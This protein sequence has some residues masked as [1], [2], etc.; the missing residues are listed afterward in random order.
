MD[1]EL[2]MD[3]IE[4]NGYLGL[5]LWLWFGVFG[6]P[7]PN[8]VISMTVGLAASLGALHPISA[9]AVTYG[10]IL[11]ALT[12]L[13]MLG[14]LVGSRLIS[15][16]EKKKRLSGTLKKS[17]MLM[18]KYHA[19]SLSFSYFI[20]GVRNFVP[21]LYG[22][23]RLSFQNFALFAY[24]GAFIWLLIVFSLGYLFGDNMEVVLKYGEEL[25]IGAFLTAL[26]L[27]AYRIIR[28]K[29]SSRMKAL[30]R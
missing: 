13:Y 5:F 30:D 8:E 26:F 19:L 12:T 3:I 6:L 16:L 9:F 4:K 1:L 27:I 20:P 21:L 2:I 23:S 22:F 14:R 11:A 15:Y 24:T 28:K 10:G 18:E 29:K 7:I 25:A 17:L